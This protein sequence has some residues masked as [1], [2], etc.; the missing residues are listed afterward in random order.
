MINIKTFLRNILINLFIWVC[1]L[2]MVLL[3]I[4]WGTLYL[5]RNYKI[6]CKNQI[7]KE[8]SLKFNIT[9]L[10]E[11]IW[12]IYLNII[13]LINICLIICFKSFINYNFYIYRFT[14]RFIVSRMG[15]EF[16]L[17]KHNCSLCPTISYIGISLLQCLGTLFLSE[18][19]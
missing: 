17:S 16:D 14:T 15:S 13:I 10:N 5:Y 11:E 7:N 2:S 4:L 19:V 3:Y 6:T 8:W 1:I 9:C 12:P 18:K